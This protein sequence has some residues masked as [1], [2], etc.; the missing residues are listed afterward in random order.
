MT[1]L[2]ERKIAHRGLH[3]NRSA[4]PENSLAAFLAA[5]KAGYHFEL[6]VR[7]SGDG[8]VVVFHDDTLA[9]MCG[10]EIRVSDLPAKEL[11]R[12]KLLDTD[13]R[14]PLLTE[15]L[16]LDLGGAG[17]IIEIKNDGPPGELED[18]LVGILKK[19]RGPCAVAC[20]NPAVVSWFMNRAPQISRG[21]IS[22]GLWNKPYGSLQK[23]YRRNLYYFAVTRPD[24]IAYDIRNLPNARVRR[25]RERGV[26]IL[27]WTARSEQD[28]V[29]ARAHCD[30]VIFESIRP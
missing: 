11:G 23:F 25:L 3:D 27:G 8:R 26:P 4:A 7:L 21:Q 17:V 30:N 15:V 29:K 24:F 20:F 1:W 5:A 10:R 6:D 13:E 9:R 22:G 12:T 2:L 16:D 18:R 19:Y 14:I 28:L